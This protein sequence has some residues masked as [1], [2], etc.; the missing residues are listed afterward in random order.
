MN[1]IRMLIIFFLALAGTLSAEI[2][3][4]RCIG[5]CDGDTITMLTSSKEQIK[6][7][8]HGID[9]PERG[10]DFGQQAR[11]KLATLLYGKQLTVS[12]SSRDRY[13][14]S[15]GKVY[16]GN[17][18]ANLE[19]VRCGLAWHYV[20]YAPDDD[21]LAAAE[22]EA[23][24]RRRGLWA[25]TQPTPPL[26]WR[27]KKKVPE[28]GV[29]AAPAASGTYWISGNNKIHNSSCRYY[30]CST[31]GEYTHF[32]RGVNCKVCGVGGTRK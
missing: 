7:R 30:G 13:G 21:S 1:P 15:V 31:N 20:R 28:T 11:Q 10:Q 29:K 12:V 26:Q 4:G 19:M 32:P 18:N 3:T 5:V 9:V 23:R 16:T 17:Q 2:Q 22:R 14:R 27:R 24:E 6:V 25:Q 8:L